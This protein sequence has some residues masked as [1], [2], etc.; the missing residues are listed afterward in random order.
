MHDSIFAMH[1]TIF[2]M[3]Q[4]SFT[5]HQSIFAMHD[6]IFAMHDVTFAMHELIYILKGEYCTLSGL[7]YLTGFGNKG[8]RKNGDRKD[9]LFLHFWAGVKRIKENP[10]ERSVR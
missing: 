5:M 6:S 4:S 2:T 10:F 1:Q 3:H 8:N 7:G 9:F